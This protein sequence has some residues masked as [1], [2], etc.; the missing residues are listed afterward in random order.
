M[1]TDWG[2]D[3]VKYDTILRHDVDKPD[4]RVDSDLADGDYGWWEVSHG[5]I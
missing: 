1:R 5:P 3:I 4:T 2:E